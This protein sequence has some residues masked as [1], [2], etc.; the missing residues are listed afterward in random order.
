MTYDPTSNGKAQSNLPPRI[1]LSG[2][3]KA[4]KTTWAAKAPKPLFIPIVGEEG[5]DDLIDKDGNAIEVMTTPVVT[6]GRF[7]HEILTWLRDGEHDYKTVV[8][9]SLSTLDRLFTKE[10]IETGDGKKSLATVNGGYGAGSGELEMRHRLVT[11]MLSDLRKKR[12]MLVIC[13]AHIADKDKKDQETMEKYDAYELALNKKSAGLYSQW[14]DY[15]LFASK[16]RYV[17]DDGKVVDKKRKLITHGKAHLPVGGRSV[18]S[19]L[20]EELDLDFAA[21]QNAVKQAKQ[22]TKGE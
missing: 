1:V 22:Q 11:Q 17:T 3:P 5:C 18:A 8:I 2:E 10:I 14:A 9:D 20:P 15:L 12:Q 16:G 21:F 6:S 13:I 7:L 4:G 19:L